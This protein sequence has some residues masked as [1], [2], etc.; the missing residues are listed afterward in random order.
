MKVRSFSRETPPETSIQFTQPLPTP[1]HRSSSKIKS[2]AML[3]IPVPSC[4]HG[5][6]RPNTRIEY[7]TRALKPTCL[8]HQH[9]LLANLKSA[10]LLPRQTSALPPHKKTPAKARVTSIENQEGTG[11]PPN[12]FVQKLTQCECQRTP[13]AN[14][15]SPSASLGPL[16]PWAQL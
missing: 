14:S 3:E 8:P 11:P 5:S 2:F 10:S 15:R 16:L 6:R 12:P 1:P 4:A 9:S 13:T 7:Q